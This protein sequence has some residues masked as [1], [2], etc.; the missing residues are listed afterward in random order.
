MVFCNVLQHLLPCQRPL[1]RVRQPFREACPPVLAS[2][3]AAVP[4][5]H[6]KPLVRGGPVLT[7]A[8]D[9]TLGVAEEYG[10]I[11]NPVLP[12]THK[13]QAG[14]VPGK[15]ALAF[16]NIRVHLYPCLTHTFY[17]GIA[18]HGIEGQRSPDVIHR[19]HHLQTYRGTRLH[20]FRTAAPGSLL[21]GFQL[22]TDGD[23]LSCP[24]QLGEIDVKGMVRESRHSLFR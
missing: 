5:Y 17:Q 23:T 8:F 7:Y 20:H 16:C 4:L 10:S 19:L 14:R 2:L 24:Y 12:S 11:R 18:Q 3:D 13:A 1:L 9:G 22:V 6:V 15:H 21:W